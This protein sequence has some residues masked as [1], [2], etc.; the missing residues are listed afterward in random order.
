MGPVRVAWL[1]KNDSKTFSAAG[2]A[3][4]PPWPP[5][6]ISAQTTRSGESEGPYPHH[7]DWLKVRKMPSPGS[8]FFSAVPVLPEMDTGKLPKIEVDVPS[9]ACVAWNKPSR[10]TARACAS[11]FVGSGAGAGDVG[12]ARPGL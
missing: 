8:I 1:P 2:A 11:T 7:Q 6:S 9:A 12:T 10:T 5:F 4:S 3:A